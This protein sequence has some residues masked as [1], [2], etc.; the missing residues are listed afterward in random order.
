VGR[1]Q[2]SVSTRCHPDT[3]KACLKM[4]QRDDAIVA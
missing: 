3:A 4:S 2:L 1:I